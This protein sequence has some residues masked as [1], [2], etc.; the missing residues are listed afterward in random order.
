M[1]VQ[2]R[3]GSQ[4]S[5]SKN[6]LRGRYDAFPAEQISTRWENKKFLSNINLAK[7]TAQFQSI[8]GL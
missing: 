3:T 2:I 5:M 6:I 1:L 4:W 7:S 8:D